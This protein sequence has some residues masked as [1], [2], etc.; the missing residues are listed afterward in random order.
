MDGRKKKDVAAAAKGEEK[1]RIGPSSAPIFFFAC[2]ADRFR[3]YG[4]ASS[5][6]SFLRPPSHFGSSFLSIVGP[7]INQLELFAHYIRGT[8]RG[9]E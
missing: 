3:I 6:G 7:A 2:V 9:R 4:S 1:N 5:P 8:Q